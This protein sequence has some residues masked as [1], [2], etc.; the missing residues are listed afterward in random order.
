MEQWWV[1]FDEKEKR[2]FWVVAEERPDDTKPCEL[3]HEGIAWIHI[4][5]FRVKYGPCT[6]NEAEEY[7]EDVR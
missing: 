1:C 5:Q 4:P 3:R 7:V 2:Y 6:K